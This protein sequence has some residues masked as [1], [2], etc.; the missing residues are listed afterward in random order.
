[1]S[2]ES[3][4]DCTAAALVVET[5]RVLLSLD[6]SIYAPIAIHK[7]GYR[8]ARR[9]TL[10]LGSTGERT[11]QVSLLLRPHTPEHEAKEVAR[12]FLRELGDQVLRA[13]LH[14]ETKGIRE[15]VLAHAFSNTDLIK[16]E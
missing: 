5:D 13:H 9:C 16:R 15:L 8:L 1:M 3:N 10:L 7:A 14:D 4:G 2:S 12:E 11:L 6:P